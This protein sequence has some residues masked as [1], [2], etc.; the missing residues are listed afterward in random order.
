MTRRSRKIVKDRLQ[1]L[2]AA[3]AREDSDEIRREAVAILGEIRQQVNRLNH[4][5]KLVRQLT[6][7]YTEDTIGVRDA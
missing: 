5:A 1:P 3:L 2:F 7:Q 6:S 4:E